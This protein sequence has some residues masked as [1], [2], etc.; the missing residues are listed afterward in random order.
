MSIPTDT[1]PKASTVPDKEGKGGCL[2]CLVR[3]LQR[4]KWKETHIG[5]CW[6]CDKGT[7]LKYWEENTPG[8]PRERIGQIYVQCPNCGCYKKDFSSGRE[9]V[10][11]WANAEPIRAGVDSET[12]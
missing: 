2:P 4:H 11:P 3:P 12:N 8:D 1:P 6:H 9:I 10:P 7:N 5:F